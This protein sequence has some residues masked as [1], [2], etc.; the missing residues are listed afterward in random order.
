MFIIFL[1]FFMF[2]GVFNQSHETV[3]I[4]GVSFRSDRVSQPSLQVD[5]FHR[6]LLLFL[7]QDD[8]AFFS[9]REEA[10]LGNNGIDVSQYLIIFL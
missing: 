7:D 5:Y 10:I 3:L 4:L 9:G 2:P 6:L 1:V 8:S